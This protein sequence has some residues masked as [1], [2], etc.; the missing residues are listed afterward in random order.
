MRD[1][2]RR[3]REYYTAVVGSCRGLKYCFP[4]SAPMWTEF[5]DNLFSD[6]PTVYI[7]VD[8]AEKIGVKRLCFS[9]CTLS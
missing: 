4:G 5:N 9:H 1:D 3:N 8:G 6:I 7:T 2:F